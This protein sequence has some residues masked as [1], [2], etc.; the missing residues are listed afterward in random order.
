[1]LQRKLGWGG[2]RLC[3]VPGF[4]LLG[5]LG[6]PHGRRDP[7]SRRVGGVLVLLFSCLH[8]PRHVHPTRWQRGEKY[9]LGENIAWKHLLFPGRGE[10]EHGG[11]KDEP[12]LW[13]A[14]SSSC[15]VSGWL[16]SVLITLTGLK[17]GGGEITG[18]V[19]WHFV[20]RG[21]Y[22][23]LYLHRWLQTPAPGLGPRL[24]PSCPLDPPG[25][26]PGSLFPPVFSRGGCKLRP[27]GEGVSLLSWPAMA[28][29]R[30]PGTAPVSWH[31]PLCHTPLPG[32]RSNTPA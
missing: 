27:G 28:R 16:V 30:C 4:Q 18:D 3:C 19:Y 32:V 15:P 1:M 5:W 6:R 26:P 11:V 8:H 2:F 17:R 13:S 9:L 21:G 20:P 24:E 12:S 23:V 29:L 7:C 31:G 22:R 25:S 14:G 10:M